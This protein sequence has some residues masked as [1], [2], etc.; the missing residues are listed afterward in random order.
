MQ[1]S[2]APPP[3]KNRR[4]TVRIQPP[5]PPSETLTQPDDAPPPPTDDVPMTEARKAA[6]PPEPVQAP[7]VREGL[8]IVAML[9]PRLA[10]RELIV[11]HQTCRLLRDAVRRVDFRPW[12]KRLALAEQR[13]RRAC[14]ADRKLLADFSSAYS[15]GQAQTA[16]HMARHAVPFATLNDVCRALRDFGPDRPPAGWWEALPGAMMNTSETAVWG[17]PAL[18]AARVDDLRRAHAVAGRICERALGESPAAQPLV[19][20][21]AFV[22]NA[23][24]GWRG[25]LYALACLEHALG[26]S[27]ATYTIREFASRLLVALVDGHWPRLKLLNNVPGRGTLFVDVL[28]ALHNLGLT[29]ALRVNHDAPGALTAEQEAYAGAELTPRTTGHECLIVEAYAGTG[30]SHSTLQ[31]AARRQA[32]GARVLVLY[33][34]NSMYQEMV[35]KLAAAAPGA[36]C[37]TMDALVLRELKRQAPDL[38]EG[39]SSLFHDISTRGPPYSALALRRAVGISEE[40]HYKGTVAKH[41]RQVCFRVRDVAS[42][43]CHSF[44]SLQRSPTHAGPHDVRA[45]SG[46]R[47]RGHRRPALLPHKEL[48]V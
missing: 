39:A 47:D 6:T 31:F 25:V 7:P 35:V 18:D 15:G 4:K 23:G 2:P 26:S 5:P 9:L 8:D 29:P 11:A 48:V 24:D 14:G 19:A 16:D 20:A 10:R 36:V 28:R 27:T 34:N 45:L 32:A 37:S 44:E 1:E 42:P 3:A 30:K 33:F 43:R 38:V 12:T 46:H 17:R 21:A 13:A 40:H 41:T 22:L